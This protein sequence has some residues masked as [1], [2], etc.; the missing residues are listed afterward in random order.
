V[1]EEGL[2]TDLAS[3]S[4]DLEAEIETAEVVAD[5]LEEAVIEAVVQRVIASTLENL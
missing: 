1:F 4:L 5:F 2:L 3:H